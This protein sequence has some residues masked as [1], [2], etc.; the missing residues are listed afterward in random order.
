MTAHEQGFIL[1]DVARRGRTRGTEKTETYYLMRVVGA[2]SA[3]TGLL[4]E[5][6]TMATKTPYAT[7]KV[8][9]VSTMLILPAS[10]LPSTVC[11]SEI[12]AEISFTIKAGIPT[13]NA[14][15]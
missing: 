11:P 2:R 13:L 15:R 10:T 7:V 14:L 6:A 3:V 9:P 12:C 8:T 5:V 4:P 1:G